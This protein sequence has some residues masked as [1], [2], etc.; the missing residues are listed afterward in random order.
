MCCCAK[1]ITCMCSYEHMSIIVGSSRWRKI[2]QIYPWTLQKEFS[3]FYYYFW[4]GCTNYTPTSWLPH[5]SCEPG[6]SKKR[7]SEEAGWCNNSCCE[8]YK[9]IWTAA[10]GEKMVSWTEGF[11]ATDLDFGSFGA[12]LTAYVVSILYSSMMILLYY[13]DLEG[14]WTV[15]DYL[16][17][18]VLVRINI[19]THIRP[20]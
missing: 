16:I 8:V 15:E 19:H 10:V 2:S 4:N 18:M 14:R 17:H 6:N 5:P 3:Q 1:F 13:S 9:S 12:S 11:S 7:Q 20:T